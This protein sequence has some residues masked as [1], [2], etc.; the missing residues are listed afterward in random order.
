MAAQSL[1]GI[2]EIVNLT[3]GKRYVG[4][5]VDIKQRW[6]CHR[7]DLKLNKHH[8]RALQR[9]WEKYGAGIFDFRVIEL[10]APAELFKREQWHLDFGL[11]EYNCSPS[12]GTCLGVK[13]D[14][15]FREK[16]RKAKTGKPLSEAHRAAIGRSLLGLKRSKD[17]IEKT[18]AAKRGKK[19]GPLADQHKRKIGAAQPS[20]RPPEFGATISRA[21][22]G[23]S[24]PDM[25]GNKFG[26]RK[27]TEAERIINSLSKKGRPKS[28][29]ARENMLRAQ[30]PELRAIRAASLKRYWAARKAKAATA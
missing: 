18:A 4:S 25:A 7:S 19:T 12:A 30:T 6:R 8:S 20:K 15:A 2:Y 13:R 22:T 11:P 9:A 23:K 10:C 1:S 21:K 27:H 28:A 14:E 29:A 16:L 24:R 26:A 3:N 5:A 17:A